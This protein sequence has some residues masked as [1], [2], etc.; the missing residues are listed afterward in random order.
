MDEKDII[1]NA[2]PQETATEQEEVLQ[3]KEEKEISAEREAIE[4]LNKYTEEDD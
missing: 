2:E 3:T 4:V 1:Q